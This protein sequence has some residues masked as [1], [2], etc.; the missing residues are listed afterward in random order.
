MQARKHRRRELRQTLHERARTVEAL[1]DAH[2]GYHPMAKGAAHGTTNPAEKDI[3]REQA[4]KL[5]RYR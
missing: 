2:R 1:V 5:K 4:P 3:A